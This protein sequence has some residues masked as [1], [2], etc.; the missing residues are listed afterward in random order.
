MRWHG[1]NGAL[2]PSTSILYGSALFIATAPSACRQGAGGTGLPRCA[3]PPTD[4]RTPGSGTTAATRRSGKGSATARPAPAP[5]PT[6]RPRPSGLGSRGAGR[7]GRRRLAATAPLQGIGGELIRSPA[8]S[9]CR[10]R[11]RTSSQ[12]NLSVVWRVRAHPHRPDPIPPIPSPTSCSPIVHRTVPKRFPNVGS[13]GHDH[14]RVVT[15]SGQD[16][17]RR[18]RLPSL[19]WMGV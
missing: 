7:P 18:L 10:G 17:Q 6:A 11:Y 1:W 3:A 14:A 12:S 13:H 16:P 5:A 8:N 2:I 19:V 9:P 15:G 4:A